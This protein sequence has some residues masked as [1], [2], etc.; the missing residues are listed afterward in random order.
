M[1][2]IPL[3]LL[4]TACDAVEDDLPGKLVQVEVTTQATDCTPARFT[5]DAGQQFFGERKDGGL[6]FTMGQQ[7]QY[8]PTLDGGTLESVQRQLVP[9]SGRS[10][11]GNGP[12]C[13]GSFSAW[14]R[15]GTGF[16]LIQ[17]WPGA[18]TCPTGPLWL[19]LRACTSTRL[20]QFTDLGT[21][22]LRCVRISLSGEIDCAC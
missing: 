13:E 15:T 5:G 6:V 14:E 20:Y 1:R 12:G 16:R 9:S 7:A 8:G 3:L 11:V 21:C 22:Q 10:A 18:D 4:L 2:L 19:P 17:Q